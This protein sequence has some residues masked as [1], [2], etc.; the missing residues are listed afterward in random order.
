MSDDTIISL[1]P[2]LAASKSAGYRRTT[3]AFFSALVSFLQEN[4]LTV[5]RLVEDPDQLSEDF[6]LAASDLT[7]EGNEVVDKGLDRWLNSINSG[8]TAPS[9]TAMLAR[10]LAKHRRR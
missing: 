6:K 10:A 4:N 9:D 8:K 1:A 7:A 5:K 2:F 3:L